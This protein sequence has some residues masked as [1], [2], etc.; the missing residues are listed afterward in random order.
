M[1]EKSD[2][3][4]NVM[5]GNLPGAEFLKGKKRELIIETYEKNVSAESYAHLW[6]VHQASLRP[7]LL[8]PPW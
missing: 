2:W 7:F 6:F 1:A 5:P 8:G 3:E 4:N